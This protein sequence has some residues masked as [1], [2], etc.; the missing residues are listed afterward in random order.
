MFTGGGGREG[1]V[2]RVGAEQKR[3]NGE[4]VENK[5]GIHL[6]MNVAIIMNIQFCAKH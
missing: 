1:R 6:F 4:R 5:V 2:W 3:G